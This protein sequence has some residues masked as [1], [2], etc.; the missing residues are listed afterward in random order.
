MSTME[1]GRGQETARDR[2]TSEIEAGIA[3]LFRIGRAWNK[4]LAARFDPDL[5]PL[6][7][8][9]LRYVMIHGPVRSADLVG[10]FDLDKASVSRQIRALRDRGLIDSTPD[11]QDGRA[12]LLVATDEAKVSVEEYR[13][14]TRQQYRAVLD[15][16]TEDEVVE[17]GRL[18][19]RLGDSLP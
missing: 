11:P 1:H 14:Q 15:Q 19:R 3:E 8:G 18:L 17:F 4:D 16:W 12:G 5:S 13:E 9:I 10:K 2:A 7:F 6:A